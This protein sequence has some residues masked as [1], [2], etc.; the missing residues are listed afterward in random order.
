VK[1]TPQQRIWRSRFEALI[2]LAAPALDLMLNVGERVSRV[3]SPED[4][5]YY[6]IRPREE[7]FEIDS[8]MREASST[9]RAGPVD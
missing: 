8:A 5:D 4:R 3:L 2:G 1:A 6:P 7:A 9:R